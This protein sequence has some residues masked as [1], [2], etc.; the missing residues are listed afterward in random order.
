L[1]RHARGARFT[2]NSVKVAIAAK[3]MLEEGV[4]YQGPAQSNGMCLLEFVVQLNL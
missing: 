3:P 2:P 1:D 4:T